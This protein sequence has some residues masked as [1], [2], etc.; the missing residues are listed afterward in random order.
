MAMTQTGK[1]TAKQGDLFMS[2]ELG[3]KLWKLS[4]TDANHGPSRY[5]VNAGDKDAIRDCI[6]KAKTRFG[7][8]PST[9]PAHCQPATSNAERRLPMRAVGQRVAREGLQSCAEV[10]WLNARHPTEFLISVQRGEVG[11]QITR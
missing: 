3:E 8:D 5:T 6:H 2:F 7:L 11:A 10:S 9:G 1:E 4:C